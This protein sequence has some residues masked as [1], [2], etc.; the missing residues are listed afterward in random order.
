MIIKHIFTFKDNT[1]QTNDIRT[2]KEEAEIIAKYHQLQDDKS[3]TVKKYEK[4]YVEY[5]KEELKNILVSC[6]SEKLK[7]VENSMYF[8]EDD[9]I[10]SNTEESIYKEIL[11]LLNQFK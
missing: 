6:I 4:K 7:L 10:K 5:S 3:T 1:I 9:R 2:S 8:D 11:D